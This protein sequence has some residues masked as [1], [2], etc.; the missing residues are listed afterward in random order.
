MS[1]K[2]DV[3]AELAEKYTGRLPDGYRSYVH[4]ADAAT[5]QRVLDLVRADA[6]ADEI[7]R[8]LGARSAPVR[9]TVKRKKPAASPKSRRRG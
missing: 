8:A 2:G 4:K 3:L 5:L 6:F 9:N 7:M 1:L